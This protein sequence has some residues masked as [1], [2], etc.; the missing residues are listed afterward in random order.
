M[1]RR[2]RRKKSRTPKII[3]GLVVLLA[4]AALATVLLW[5]SKHGPAHHAVAR[6]TPTVTLLYTADLQGRLTPTPCEE[7]SLGGIARIATLFGQWQAEFPNCIVV[8]AGN[9]SVP[10]GGDAKTI[11]PFACQALDMLGAAVV[12]C[13]P[14]EAALPQD[15]LKDLAAD[16]R[17]YTMVSAN[18][19]DAASGNTIFAPS[20]TLA[21]GGT[22]VTF[23]GLVQ[24]SRLGTG[25]RLLEPE[26]ALR[27]TLATL[28]TDAD[29][30]VVLACLPPAT[31]YDLARKFPKV[32]A[33][34]GGDA[35]ASSAPYENVANSLVAYL[36]ERG[37][38]AGCLHASFPTKGRPVATGIIRRL[39][40]ELA[41]APA[42]KPLVERF[43]AAVP[44]AKRPDAANDPKIPC[45]ASFVGSDVCK[46]CHI[47][48][49]YSWQARAHAG[50]YVTL[51]QGKKQTD[52]TC[53]PCHVT[54][55]HMPNGYDTKL[56][57]VTNEK[58]PKKKQDN[59]RALDTLKNVGC[60]SCHGGARRH[61][62]V[63]LKDRTQAAK[64]PYQRPEVSTRSCSRCHTGVRPC[65]PKGTTDPY[66]AQDYL[67]KIKHWQ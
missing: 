25:L 23:V 15:Q 9:A 29:L 1:V 54:G 20:H 40:P 44:P 14:N 49:Y 63:A 2:R 39:D 35:Q 61:V 34:I 65:L 13:G 36:G 47:S 52:T 37:Y 30:V 53:L 27:S 67:D 57:A 42:V 5:G 55:Y 38:A 24:T 21:V 18:L 64:T 12:N 17:K 16:I 8:D 22:R 62:A 59:Q 41:D 45:T 32:R 43:T 58:D 60:E 66:S 19:L 26:D 33:F 31:I 10:P 51:L 4:I 6:G 56:N 7:G 50:A 46:L 48:E 3:F 11:N 28:D